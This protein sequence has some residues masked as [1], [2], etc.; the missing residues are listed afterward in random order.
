MG[1]KT[2]K[3]IFLEHKLLAADQLEKAAVEAKNTQKPL[4]QVVVDMGLVERVDVLQTLSK[5]WRVRAVDLAEMDVDPEVVKIVSE[6]NARRHFAI[7]FAKEER[8]LLVAMADPRD[9]FISEDIHLRTGFEVQS[10]LALPEDI[11]REL[12]K[13]YGVAASVSAEDMVKGITEQIPETDGAISLEKME[14]AVDVTEVDASAPEVERIVNAVIVGALQSKASD[15]H[16]EPFESKFLVRYRV[17]GNLREAAFQIPMS[18]RNA[19]I[20]KI[21]IMTNQMDI[22][23]R[24]KPQDGRIQVS[25]KGNPV[26]FRVNIVPTVF[27]ESCVMRVLD[28]AS[29]RVDLNKL[30]FHPELL[31]KF[32]NVLARPY[33]LIL[34]CGPTGSGKS[35]TLYA[36]L[37][38]IN[39][40]DTKILTAENPVEYNLSGII[41]TNVNPDIGFTFAEALRAFLRQD[42]DIIMVGEIR[43]KETAQ[44][45][46][47]AAMTG[48]LVFSTIHTNDA[49]SA[50][51]R[52]HEMGVPSFLVSGTVEGVLAQRLVR[53]VCSSCAKPTQATDEMKVVFEKY[54]I[55]ISKAK[56][57]KGKGCDTCNKTGFKGRAGI[58]EL[59]LMDDDIRRILLT[60]VSAQPIR[61]QAVKNGM[62]L[63]LLDGLIKVTNGVTT[64]EEVFAATQ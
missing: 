54:Q 28:R 8:V 29:V 53:R 13:V 34:V 6:Q 10:Y 31:E 47:E 15:I 35:T 63:M 30:G 57:M 43:D 44:I 16:I 23:E 27:G 56:F 14:E 12:G 3:D 62:R 11:L 17:D 45:A 20:A 49:P 59:L 5:E 24:R 48:H 41:Q 37:N 7:P 22:T 40:P 33:G 2:I 4:Q 26:E 36:A 51:A 21:K 64:M 60:E 61:E 1:R 50:V 18:Y 19:V 52:L 25:A 55:D 42:P 9:F 38:S 32:K 58:H 46:M 39:N